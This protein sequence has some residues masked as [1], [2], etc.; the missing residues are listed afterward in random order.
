MLKEKDMLPCPFCGSK[1]CV[2]PIDPNSDG[3]WGASCMNE[4]SDCAGVIY[5][6]NAYYATA[7]DAVAAWN[8]RQPN[9][10]NQALTRERQ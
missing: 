9:A 2:E 8:R 5:R 6:P 1:A 10:E 3:P 7:A 4:E